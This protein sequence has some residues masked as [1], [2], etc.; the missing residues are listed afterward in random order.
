MLVQSFCL[1]FIHFDYNNY[2]FFLQLTL[3]AQQLEA[4]RNY[5]TNLGIPISASNQIVIQAPTQGTKLVIKL[6]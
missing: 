2:L 4:I 5:I 3:T 1:T 6:L